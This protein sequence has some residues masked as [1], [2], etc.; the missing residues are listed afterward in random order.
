MSSLD[1]LKLEKFIHE[2]LKEDLHKLEQEL[3]KINTEIIEFMELQ[4]TVE[5]I[6]KYYPVGDFKTKMNIGA[7]FFMQ[8]KVEDT[9]KILVNVGCGIYVEFDLKEAIKFVNFK[10][11]ILQKHADIV[12]DESIKVK[13][14]IKLALMCISQNTNMDKERS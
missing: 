4:T 14:N 10:L 3:I 1:T 8:A 5:C 2:H 11:R 7:N 6:Q 9:S 13:A 12:R